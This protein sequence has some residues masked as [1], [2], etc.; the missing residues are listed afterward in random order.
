M[1]AKSKKSGGNTAKQLRKRVK[2]LER[3]LDEL[4]TAL[5]TEIVTRRLVVIDEE[6]IERIA[7]QTEPD[8]G[9]AEVKVSTETDDTYVVLRAAPH[10][11]EGESILEL[12][13][14][15]DGNSVG[16]LWV[17]GPNR[18]IETTNVQGLSQK[19]R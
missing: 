18:P 14:W 9:L 11:F 17:L 4:K 19:M 1:G 3:E 15:V 13:Y 16:D 2:H 10:A 7:L 5:A 12:A 8:H 6:D